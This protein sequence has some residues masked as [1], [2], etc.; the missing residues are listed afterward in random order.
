MQLIYAYSIS[1]LSVIY[2]GFLKQRA[3]LTRLTL[4][5]LASINQSNGKTMKV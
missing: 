4:L 1:F 5:T 3:V 2:Y